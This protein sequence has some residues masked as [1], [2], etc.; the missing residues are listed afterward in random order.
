MRYTDFVQFADI[1]NRRRGGFARDAVEPLDRLG[2]AAV[3]LERGLA[4][5]G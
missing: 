5:P 4:S 1:Y 3:L 2:L